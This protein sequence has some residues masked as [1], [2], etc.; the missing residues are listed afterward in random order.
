MQIEEPEIT[1]PVFS[2][3]RSTKILSSTPKAKK[4][5]SL[6]IISKEEE[7]CD[8]IEYLIGGFNFVNKNAKDLPLITSQRAINILLKLCRQE[9]RDY[10]LNK[11]NRDK[12]LQNQMEEENSKSKKKRENIEDTTFLR[13][14][15]NWALD[16]ERSL[17]VRKLLKTEKKELKFIEE[18]SDIPTV[19]N[20][21]GNRED[22]LINIIKVSKFRTKFLRKNIKSNNKENKSSVVEAKEENSDDKMIEEE[23][24]I[25]A[26]LIE[27][28]NVEEFTKEENL[29]FEHHMNII[30]CI[31]NSEIDIS[32]KL[33]LSLNYLKDEILEFGKFYF[34]FLA[35]RTF[36]LIEMLEFTTEKHLN[37]W[38]NFINVKTI[39]FNFNLGTS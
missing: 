35:K 18:M 21:M 6:K 23:E 24:E 19:V 5:N 20:E 11:K 15:D 32:L 22:R 17:D 2:N 31:Y 33:E 8:K 12:E 10:D 34:R 28:K 30:E 38:E 7:I 16:V 36:E 14:R 26:D 13:K 37:S 3:A 39:N 27:L 1:P 25:I 4:E 9:F 29:L